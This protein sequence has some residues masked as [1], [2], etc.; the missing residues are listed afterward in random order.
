MYIYFYFKVF[1]DGVI[2]FNFEIRYIVGK[3]YFFEREKYFNELEDNFFIVLFFY[4][5][6]FL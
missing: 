2:G 3:I 4:G 6:V 1:K 5:G